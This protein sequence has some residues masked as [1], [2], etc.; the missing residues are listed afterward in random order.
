[1]ESRPASRRR[2]LGILLGLSAWAFVS[3]A[4]RWLGF[5]RAE[6]GDVK[7]YG[8][9]GFFKHRRSAEVIGREYLKQTPD[10]RNTDILLDRLLEGGVNRAEFAAAGAGRRREMLRELTREDFA[11]GRV[12]K[13]GGWILSLTEARLCAL[14]GVLGTS[15]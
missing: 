7:A 6:A 12:V 5:D 15:G 11:R 4:G 9:G 1:M 10:E 8:L 2:F 3:P 13:V 14:A